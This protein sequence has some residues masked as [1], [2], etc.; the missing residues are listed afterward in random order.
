[1]VRAGAATVHPFL[2]FADDSSL[3]GIS[4]LHSKASSHNVLINDLDVGLQGVLS[5]FA[6]DTQLRGAADSTKSGEALGRD[7]DN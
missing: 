6:D 5:E 4:R 3:V 1:M 2:K 7:L